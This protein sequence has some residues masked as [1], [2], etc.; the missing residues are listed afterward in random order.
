MDTYTLAMTITACVLAVAH[1]LFRAANRRL[2]RREQVSD[3]DIA[4]LIAQMI[5][6]QAATRSRRT[7]DKST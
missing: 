6:L 5:L 4:D 7:A 3:D 1:F 2:E